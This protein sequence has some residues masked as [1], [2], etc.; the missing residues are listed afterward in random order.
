MKA[1]RVPKVL[2]PKR[3]GPQGVKARRGGAMTFFCIL[4]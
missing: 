1:S 3:L 2:A 4:A